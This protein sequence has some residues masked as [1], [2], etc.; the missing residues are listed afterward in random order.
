[1]GRRRTIT[2]QERVAIIDLYKDGM[3]MRRVAERVGRS[4]GAVNQ[5]LHKAGVTIA[6][7]GGYRRTPV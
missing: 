6:P 7:R 3:V 4:Y 5:V 2:D 1:M